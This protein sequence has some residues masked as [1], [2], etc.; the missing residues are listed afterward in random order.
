MAVTASLLVVVR[1]AQ[2][3]ATMM[4]AISETVSLVKASPLAQ[5]VMLMG[6]QMLVLQTAKSVAL[7]VLM[8]RR[9]PW[10]AWTTGVAFPTGHGAM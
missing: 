8:V 9:W 4:A 2:T 6:F 1:T 3:S 5:N 7:M 10:R